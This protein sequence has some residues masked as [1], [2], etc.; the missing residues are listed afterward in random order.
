[1]ADGLT[2]LRGVT[3]RQL[4]VFSAVARRL[5]FTAAARE[6]H[7][8]Q[9]AVSMQ[10]KELEA[11]CGLA[12][13]ERAGRGVR[14][15]EAGAELA[16]SAHAIGERLRHAEEVLDALRG[17]R[18]GLLRLGAVSTAKYFA[19]SLLS[20]FGREHPDIGIRFTVGNREEMIRLLAENEADLVVM[21]RPPAELETEAE[22]FAKHPLIVV[23]APTHPLAR[24]RR[25]S[26]ERLQE[27]RFLIR[28]QGSGTRAAMEALFAERGLRYSASME[29]SSNE[30]I[31][32]AVIAGMGISL[33]SAH[34]VGLEL[35]AGR[36]AALRVAGLPIVR[37]WFVIHAKGKR[38]SP[39]TAAF[40]RFLVG[41]G[42]GIIAGAVGPSAAALGRAPRPGH[43]LE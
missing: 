10:V 37:D 5:S 41:E 28:E 20:A 40:R 31:K 29:V 24:Q 1:M 27:E 6:L 21:G 3:L 2:A 19:P 26:L 30:T 18:R 22:A 43:Q 35:E 23:A 13:F 4:R 42:A 12:L 11:A 39:V 33:L 14:L 25:I 34:T 9:P 7:L 36:I 17:L 8:T 38:L 16:A 15:T 32:Q